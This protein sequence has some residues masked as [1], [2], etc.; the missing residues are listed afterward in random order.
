MFEFL[1]SFHC[2]NWCLLMRF[3]TGWEHDPRRA[4]SRGS[5]RS[6]GIIIFT[7]MAVGLLSDSGWTVHYF[8]MTDGDS[9][10]CRWFQFWCWSFIQWS[11]DCFYIF[12]WW[13]RPPRSGR[14]MQARDQYKRSIDALGR[15]EEFKNTI[16][17]KL[18]TAVSGYAEVCVPCFLQKSGQ[19]YW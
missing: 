5:V 13:F 6:T 2:M 19:T 4:A 16:L 10:L 3:K 15:S 17:A 18:N 9:N 1:N 11:L 12:K 14:L 7:S 8:S